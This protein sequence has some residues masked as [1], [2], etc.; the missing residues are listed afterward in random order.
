MSLFAAICKNNDVQTWIYKANMSRNEGHV[1]TA[2]SIISATLITPKEIRS[3]GSK[4][5]RLD[6][7]WID[8]IVL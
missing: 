7:V 8:K 4:I 3:E 5:F 2:A 1:D 6:E